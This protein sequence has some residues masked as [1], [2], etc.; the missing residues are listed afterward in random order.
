M[1]IRSLSNGENFG[2][3]T[4]LSRD[5]LAGHVEQL[6]S[7]GKLFQ[8]ADSI[9]IINRLDNTSALNFL[10]ESDSY[11]SP[12]KI[13]VSPLYDKNLKSKTFKITK[14]RPFYGVLKKLENFYEKTG[15][16]DLAAFREE[17]TLMNLHNLHKAHESG[18]NILAFPANPLQNGLSPNCPHL[19]PK[20]RA[21]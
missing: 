21:K 5:Y 9:R 4:T 18:E 12:A 8:A 11:S 14:F 20:L 13:I 15:H 19:S 2:K 7:K 3:W 10:Y 16:S 6:V 17:E 1:N